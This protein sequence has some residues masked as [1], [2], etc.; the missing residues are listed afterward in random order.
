VPR[1]GYRPRMG[2]TL[3]NVVLLTAASSGRDDNPSGGGG[4]LVVVG[5]VVAVL[6]AVMALGLFLR[7][8][9]SRS[10]GE[11]FRRRPHRRGR[12]GRIR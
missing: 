11:I 8:R 6:V 10:R 3:L 4:V 12:V 1:L 2:A 5:I 9:R 7:N